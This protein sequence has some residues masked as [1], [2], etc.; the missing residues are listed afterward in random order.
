MKNALL[1]DQ[2]N[3]GTRSESLNRAA[4][5]IWTNSKAEITAAITALELTSI[6]GVTG[7][8]NY[9]AGSELGAFPRLYGID[10]VRQCHTHAALEK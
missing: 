8:R 1:P 7:H 5:Y 6:L 10:S 2:I 4:I 3:H 9:P